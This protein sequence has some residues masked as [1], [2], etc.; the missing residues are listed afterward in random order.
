MWL[1][2]VSF[3]QLVV[4]GRSCYAGHCMNVF[5]T[6]QRGTKPLCS[7]QQESSKIFP[8]P[9]LSRFARLSSWRVCPHLCWDN[10]LVYPDFPGFICLNEINGHS[11]GQFLKFIPN[12]VELS[13]FGIPANRAHPKRD[14]AKRNTWLN[15]YYLKE[16]EAKQKHLASKLL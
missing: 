10:L 14:S 4:S 8:P 1:I 5:K 2:N 16:H 7:L 6:W 13:L 12:C 15:N 3:L 11:C 9:L